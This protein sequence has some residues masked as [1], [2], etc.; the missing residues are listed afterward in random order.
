MGISDMKYKNTAKSYKI[1]VF[2][3]VKVQI[4]I[5]NEVP[6]LGYKLISNT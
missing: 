1:V 4:L 2:P 6:S 5:Y 3:G